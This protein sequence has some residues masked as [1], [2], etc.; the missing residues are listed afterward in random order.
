M[1]EQIAGPIESILETYSS[2]SE[3]SIVVIIRTISMAQE[4]IRMHRS[5][6]WL[7]PY[8]FQNLDDGQ[9]L[10]ML[11]DNTAMHQGARYPPVLRPLPYMHGNLAFWLSTCLV[12]S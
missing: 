6:T 8:V 10:N 5:G 2:M 11:K 9:Y 12:S 7:E 1:H 4:R 3:S